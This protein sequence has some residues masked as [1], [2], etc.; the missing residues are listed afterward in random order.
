MIYQSKPNPNYNTQK[1]TQSYVNVNEMEVSSK[2]PVDALSDPFTTD[3]T[4]KLDPYTAHLF[5]CIV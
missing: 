3:L 1:N 4:H 5:H 2:N